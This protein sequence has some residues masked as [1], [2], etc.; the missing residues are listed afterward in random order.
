MMLFMDDAKIHANIFKRNEYTYFLC[1][2]LHKMTDTR[3]VQSSE[4]A[5]A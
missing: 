3:R 5:V 2:G 4:L 1:R